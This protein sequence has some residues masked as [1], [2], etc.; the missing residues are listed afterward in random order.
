M[1]GHE[2]RHIARMNKLEQ[3]LGQTQQAMMGAFNLVGKQAKRH[4]QVGYL[5]HALNFVMLGYVLAKL[6][7]WL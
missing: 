7:G 1:T 6:L 5:L 3:T 2:Q 4:R